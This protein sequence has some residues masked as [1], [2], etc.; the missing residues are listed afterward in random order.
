MRFS[1]ILGVLFAFGI[2]AGD[3]ALADDVFGFIYIPAILVC[4]FGTLGL[5]YLSYGA[6]DTLQALSSLRLLIV[7]PGTI[8][9]LDRRTE[10]I[11]GAI[12][13]LYACGV[14]G[15]MISFLKMLAFTAAKHT[16][17]WGL[18][19]SLISCLPL[20]YAVVGS[21]F[22]LRPASRRLDGLLRH[23]DSE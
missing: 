2:L 20:F 12:V 11:R 1:G 15:T 22:L 4:V 7:S 19:P 8:E 13:H 16:F 10:V 6:L 5:C 3:I 18:S 14:I 23:V 9:G 21:E 17:I